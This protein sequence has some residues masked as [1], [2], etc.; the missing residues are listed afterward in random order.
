MRKRG[1]HLQYSFDAR[2]QRG[3]ELQN[4]LF[5]LLQAVLQYGSISGAAR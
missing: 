5:D 3:A 2:G 1:I 4:P